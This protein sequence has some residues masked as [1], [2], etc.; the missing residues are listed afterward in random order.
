[1]KKAVLTADEAI[2]LITDSRSDSLCCNILTKYTWLYLRSV[3]K[4]CSRSYLQGF[5][6]VALC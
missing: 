2:A 4:P 1:M 6:F 3:Q 5:S